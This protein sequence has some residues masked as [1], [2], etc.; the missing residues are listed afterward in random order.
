MRPADVNEPSGAGDKQIP[1][2]MRPADANEPSGG[3]RDQQRAAFDANE[4]GEILG[5][6]SPSR[7][8]SRKSRFS[9]VLPAL[10]LLFLQV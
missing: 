6:E 8:A 2:N 5:D 10:A 3:G 1:A 9:W 4:T 7:D